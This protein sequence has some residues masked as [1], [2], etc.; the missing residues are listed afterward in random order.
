MNSCH[1]GGAWKKPGTLRRKG[2]EKDA[3]KNL[4]F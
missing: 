2:K 4:M 3:K 1:K